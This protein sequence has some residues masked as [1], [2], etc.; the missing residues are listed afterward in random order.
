[1]GTA[2]IAPKRAKQVRRLK[3]EWLVGKRNRQF[4]AQTQ[5]LFECRHFFHQHALVEMVATC[6]YSQG[7]IFL[8]PTQLIVQEAVKVY[9]TN[10]LEGCPCGPD[11]DFWTA[12]TPQLDWQRTM[13]SSQGSIYLGC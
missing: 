10:F 5:E 2:C 6:P 9:N 4:L 1:M 11:G 12:G 8:L 7:L 3:S 13:L